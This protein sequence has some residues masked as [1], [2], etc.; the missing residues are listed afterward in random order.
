MRAFFLLHWR[1]YALWLG[2]VLLLAATTRTKVAVNSEE[3]LISIF[4]RRMFLILIVAFGLSLVWGSIQEG[5]MFYYNALYNF[6]IYYAWLLVVALSAAVWIQSQA[7]S[8]PGKA[9][10]MGLS[11]LT[12]LAVSALYKERRHFRAAPNADENR[13]F[14]AAVERALALDPAQPKF[15]NFDWQGGG[16]TTRVALYLE[17]KGVGWWVREDW[18]LLFGEERIIREGKPGQPVPQLESS[19]WRI[20]W[21]PNL[22]A[23][24]TTPNAT[25]IP[26]TAGYD[27]IVYPGKTKTAP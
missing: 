6:A 18:P 19:F 21:H 3:R 24:A 26:L 12:L 5:P 14:A 23:Q 4:T 2:S 22:L 13:F 1:A 20:V 25:V 17:R 27:L 8:W 16:Q 11:A 15:L 9:R 7:S 10:V